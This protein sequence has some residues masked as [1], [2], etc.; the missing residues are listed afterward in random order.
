VSVAPPAR[1]AQ[2]LGLVRARLLDSLAGLRA[3]RLALVV[4]PAGTGKTTLLAHYAEQW[5]GPVGWWHVDP[6]GT[7]VDG[8]VARVWRAVAG[9]SAA[10]PPR[11]VDDL[12]AALADDDTA[13]RLLVVDDLHYLGRTEA[14]AALEAII[15]R[16]PASLHIL[17][18]G[19][20]MPGLNLSRHE[21]SATA[22]LN[23]EDLRFRSWEVEYLLADV[24]RE[25]LP[26]D[27]AAALARRV[28]GWAAGL[29]MFHLSTS[30][31]PLAER[32]RAVA[33]L[34]GRSALTQGYLARTVLAELPD[35]LR[36][37]MVRTCVFEVLTVQRCERLLG[38][39]GTSR[40]LLAELARRQ[41]LTST[42]DGGQTYRY[43][44]VLRAH[45][46]VM[47]AEGLGDAAARELH[48][49]AAD[50]LLADGAH[51]EATR[52]YA[53]AEDWAAVRRLL[54]KLEVTVADEEVEP[55]RDLLPGWLAAGDPWL[56]YAEAR[57]ML[58]RGR[59]GPAIDR[60]RWAEAHFCEEQSRARCRAV[61]Q[62]AAVW[63]PGGAASGG[64]ASGGA[65]SGGAA[66]GGA[67]SGGQDFGQLRTA[68]RGHPA[69]VA[70][71][72][73]DQLFV[74][75]AAHLLAGNVT[76][77]VRAARAVPP[78]APG[79]AGLAGAL[80]RA[81]I[82]VAAGVPDGRHLLASAL[83][84]AERARL[85]WL[86]RMARAAEVLDGSA[87]GAAEVRAVVRE[88]DRDGD[89][90]G[91]LLARGLGCLARSVAEVG[92]TADVEDAT[93]LL[94]R[95]RQV[96]AGVLAAWAQALLA[97]ATARAGLPDS[98]VEAQRADALAR[99]AGVPGARVAALAAAVRCGAARADMAAMAVECGLPAAVGAGWAG[100]QAQAVRGNEA[101]PIEVWCF[102]GFRMRRRGV[103]LDW[104]TIKPRTRV[105]LRLLAMHAGRPVH[106]ETLIEALWP[107][108]PP[109]AATRN[110]H[111]ALSS[112]RTFLE[113]GVP[114]GQSGLLLRHGEAYELALPDNSYSD[115]AT[116]HSALDT[117]RRARLNDDAAAALDLATLQLARGE[118]GEAVAAAERCVQIDRYCDPGWRFLAEACDALRNPAA[119][120]RVRREYAGVL[121]SL[122]IAPVAA[123]PRPRGYE[124]TKS[125]SSPMPHRLPGGMP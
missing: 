57:Q 13:D 100:R 106:R 28:G 83:A 17:A 36:E 12:V 32:Q 9:P 117:A 75:A 60:L 108:M 50:L 101:Q 88:C 80:L 119:A 81:C 61:R 20:L 120:A 52:A 22:V 46:A 2:R 70:S 40:Q 66:S 105:A 95:C 3:G 45:L 24:Y 112:L 27:D 14:E 115:V 1:P 78:D 68:V 54:G 21:L 34:D 71:A 107:D 64:A 65:A 8:V 86:V 31:R 99:S 51:V 19:R 123:T 10:D 47:L 82:E 118:A 77:A 59:L 11:G 15:L 90:W 92:E 29:H 37:F 23:A 102:G 124:R 55:L 18:G 96:D 41:A 111:V 43:H 84:D 49:R 98:D 7:T 94:D 85:P 76:E 58:G 91:A 56:G 74:R 89:A 121:A 125:S 39:P 48:S 122:D 42:N 69:L 104:S 116:F 44:E 5:Q 63:L 72:A 110:L 114:R 35:R 53:R 67:A 97:L 16:A 38:E 93:D 109:A 33:A 87:R 113:P 73:K 79:F 25:P 103:A 6:G 26:P 4:A 30:G 62:A